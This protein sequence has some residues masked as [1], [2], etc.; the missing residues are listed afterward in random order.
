MKKVCLSFVCGAIVIAATVSL[1]TDSAQAFPQFAKGFQA[2]YIGDGS[3]DAQKSLAV[4]FKAA[5][6]CNTCHD[7]NK[8]TPE[9]KKSK[10]FRNAYGEALHK[11]LGKKDKKDKAKILASLEKI[12][13]LKAE[14]AGQ[15]Y[16]QRI[17]AGKLPIEKK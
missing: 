17:K 11:Y 16:G 7:P 5:K 15:T 1:K 8:R 12:E 4:A 10:K 3:T 9:G 2:K 13:G 14:G 6:K